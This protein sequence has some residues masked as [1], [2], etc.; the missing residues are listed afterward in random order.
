M[1]TKKWKY[2]P[3]W[4]LMAMPGLASAQT[5][6]EFGDSVQIWLD[7]RL[8]QAHAHH[9]ERVQ[10]PLSVRSAAWGC[11]CPDSYIG[12]S[13]NT[14]E[15]PWIFVLAPAGFP[16][17]DSAGHALI[18]EGYFTGKF[19][20]QDLRNPD[21]NPAEWLY[22]IPRFRVKSWRDNPSYGEA[23]PPRVLPQNRWP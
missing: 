18:V 14:Q 17:V 23:L 10:M 15:G 6:L 8:A 7:E 4:I 1:Q 11:K 12:E 19:K 16:K 20:T 21:G 2:W 13:P 9:R 22:R 5:Y 3:L